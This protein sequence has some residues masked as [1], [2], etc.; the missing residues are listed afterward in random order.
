MK[1]EHGDEWWRDVVFLLTMAI[2]FVVVI[3]W[4][5]HIQERERLSTPE[6]S[7][8]APPGP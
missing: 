8:T 7:V 5:N 3:T 6:S 1:E 2:L 4:S